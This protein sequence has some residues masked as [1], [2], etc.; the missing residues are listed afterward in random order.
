MLVISIGAWT[1][2][3]PESAFSNRQIDENCWR[4][5]I[6]DASISSAQGW[7]TGTSSVIVDSPT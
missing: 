5:L 4:A 7:R 2:D 3:G 1:G 6:A